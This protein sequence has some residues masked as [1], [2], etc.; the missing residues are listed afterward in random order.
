VRADSSVSDECETTSKTSPNLREIS[1]NLSE[2]STN[3]REI[4]PNLREISSNLREISP[5]LREISPNLREISPNEPN[6]PGNC[7]NIFLY[8]GQPHLLSTINL[9]SYIILILN[10]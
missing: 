2:T 7:Y 9:P 4:S 1:P 6:F 5:N 3:L 10:F 8:K